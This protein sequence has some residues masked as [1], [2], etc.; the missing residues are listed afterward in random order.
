MSEPNETIDTDIA[1]DEGVSEEANESIEPTN[2]DS[3]AGREASAVSDEEIDTLADTAK[4]VLEEILA[5]FRLEDYEIDEFE[6]DE[7]ELILDIAGEDMNRLIGY[8]GRTAEALQVV[9]AAIA[10][11]RCGVY[12]PVTIDV[13]GYKHRRKQKVIDI[14]QDAAERAISTGREI[15][16]KPMNPAERRQVHM[17]LSEVASVTTESEGRGDYR[18]VVVVPAE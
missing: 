8:H 10:C 9:A 18:H 5:F 17:A 6:G 15:T 7:G 14:A 12:Y 11:R 13:A 2:A 16:L 3:R 1:S 4:E